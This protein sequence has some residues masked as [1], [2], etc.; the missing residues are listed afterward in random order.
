[1]PKDESVRQFIF[2]GTTL[3]RYLP[4][5]RLLNKP[6]PSGSARAVLASLNGTSRRGSDSTP[7]RPWAGGMP[8]RQ[9]RAR[10]S[11]SAF[12]RPR[13]APR[14]RDRSLTGNPRAWAVVGCP[15]DN[16]AVL[17]R[18]LAHSIYLEYVLPLLA[19]DLPPYVVC[20]IIECLVDTE[21]YPHFY[22]I[23]MIMRM[24]KFRETVL[25]KRNT[26]G[27]KIKL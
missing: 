11:S 23:A 22:G 8:L 24:T 6:R 4:G 20:E 5:S 19:L 13:T 17:K 10:P 26:E 14:N 21:M 25:A 27:K 1:M 3:T 15:K 7:T 12:R 2:S 9:A 18:K 16:A